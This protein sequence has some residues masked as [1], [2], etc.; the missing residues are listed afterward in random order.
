MTQCNLTATAWHNNHH[1]YKLWLFLELF[2]WRDFF[3]HPFRLH[4]FASTVT[5]HSAIISPPSPWDPSEEQ[6]MKSKNLKQRS[7]EQREATKW[8]TKSNEVKDTKEHKE[9]QRNGARR[10]V[11]KMN[12]EI[13]KVCNL[14]SSVKLVNLVGEVTYVPC[15]DKLT[16]LP[17]YQM[18]CSFFI[19]RRVRIEKSTLILT[20]RDVDSHIMLPYSLSVCGNTAGT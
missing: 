18:V 1:L 7:E 5:I 12:V 9:K 4:Y 13:F 14:W 17:T 20:I 11:T 16:V 6:K 3:C 2:S 15:S 10:E 19:D 8:S